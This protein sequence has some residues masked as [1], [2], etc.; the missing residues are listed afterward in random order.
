[1]Q[2]YVCPNCEC[3]ITA[4]PLQLY[5]SG[6]VVVI[7]GED[8]KASNSVSESSKLLEAP[9]VDIICPRCGFTQVVTVGMR[10]ES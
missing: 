6:K 1:M 7:L 2:T 5:S 8:A 9:H 10:N 3:I 4:D